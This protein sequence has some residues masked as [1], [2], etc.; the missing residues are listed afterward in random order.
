MFSSSLALPSTD[1]VSRGRGRGGGD[2]KKK[3]TM[4]LSGRSDQK[5]SLVIENAHCRFPNREK[6]KGIK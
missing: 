4:K 5:R 3:S 2:P 1:L 6:K